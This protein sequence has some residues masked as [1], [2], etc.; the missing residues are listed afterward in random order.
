MDPTT[1]RSWLSEIASLTDRQRRSAWQALA[2]SETTASP[3]AEALA[4]LEPARV[5]VQP[6]SPPGFPLAV[7]RCT[8]SIAQLGQ[9][10]VD[11]AGCPH[12]D[13]G[14]V[15]RWGRASDLPRYRCKSCLRTFNALSK[16]PLAKLRMKAKWAVQ[17]EALI[18]GVTLAQAARRCGVH[19]T[20]AF[21][22]RHRFLTA[23]SGDKPKA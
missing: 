12:C 4:G 13:S 15:V 1:F 19:P 17:T 7:A 8:A 18:D 5:R 11:S 3:G 14:D 21:R 9:C 6:A 10:R 20:T 22:R 16:T 23:L 2:L